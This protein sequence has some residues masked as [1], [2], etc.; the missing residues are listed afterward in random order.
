MTIQAIKNKSLIIWMLQEKEFG[1]EITRIHYRKLFPYL[2]TAVDS[3]S[4]RKLII[5]MTT[6]RYIQITS[7]SV[8]WRCCRGG[9]CHHFPAPPWETCECH[10]SLKATRTLHDSAQKHTG[11]SLICDPRIVKHTCQWG[12]FSSLRKEA[13]P[14]V[15]QSSLCC[16][17]TQN[18]KCLHCRYFLEEFRII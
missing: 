13:P 8:G 1:T 4:T 18:T 11:T 10:G 17:S 14:Y 6:C 16:W 9:S 15:K 12:G 5:K 7:D 3:Y 2:Y